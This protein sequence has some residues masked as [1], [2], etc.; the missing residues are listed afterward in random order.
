MFNI[1]GAKKHPNSESTIATAPFRSL[2]SYFPC[3]PASENLSGIII[4]VQLKNLGL[5]L[6]YFSSEEKKNRSNFLIKNMSLYLDMNVNELNDQPTVLI[7]T[8]A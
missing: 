3:T 7:W 5:L 6:L 2:Q 1:S 4:S 8:A